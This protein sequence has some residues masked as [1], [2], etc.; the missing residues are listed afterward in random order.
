[1][2]NLIRHFT[3][4][5]LIPFSFSAK[6]QNDSVEKVH[7]IAL[8][9]PLYLDSAFDETGSYRFDKNFPKLLNPGLEFYE[10]AQMAIDSL[11]K[12]GVPLEVT[13]YD[14]KSTKKTIAQILQSPEF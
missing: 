6:A 4:L 9:A 12:E 11:Q 3:F 13:L 14:T 2:K 7:H 8:F 10:G 5:I 1:M